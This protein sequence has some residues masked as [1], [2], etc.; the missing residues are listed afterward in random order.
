MRLIVASTTAA[1]IGIIVCVTYQ[2]GKGVLGGDLPPWVTVVAVLLGL[3]STLL[4]FMTCLLLASDRRKTCTPKGIVTL[5]Y[6]FSI[7]GA[8]FLPLLAQ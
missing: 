2:T 5:I 4:T 3:G 1:W 6:G 8:L 7:V